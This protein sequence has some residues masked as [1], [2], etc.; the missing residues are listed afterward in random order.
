MPDVP[1][2]A[3][4]AALAKR[5]ALLADRPDPMV[6]SDESLVRQMLEAALP[7]LLPPAPDLTAVPW[8]QGRRKGRNLYAVTGDDWEAHPEI[9]CL[10]TAELAA[11]ACAAHNERLGRP[12]PMREARHT[13]TGRATRPGALSPSVPVYT[14]GTPSL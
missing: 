8:R 1:A 13:A 9:G 11:E 2:A 10:D 5:A 6:L 3:I 7:Y 4:A 12:R 14:R